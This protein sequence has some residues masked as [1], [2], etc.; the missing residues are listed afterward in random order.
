LR[1]QVLRLSKTKKCPLMIEMK[2]SKRKSKMKTFRC[3]HK[4]KEK[5]RGLGN[6]TVCKTLKYNKR[7]QNSLD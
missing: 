7:D 3:S 1:D 2:E 4:E 5:N 6:N